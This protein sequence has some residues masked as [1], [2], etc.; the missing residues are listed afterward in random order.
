[1]VPVRPDRPFTRFPRVSTLR[2]RPRR[3]VDARS[4]AAGGARGRVGRGSDGLRQGGGG[5]G[6]DYSD[7]LASG[8]GEQAGERL[9]ERLVLGVC[10][11]EG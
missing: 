7:T 2:H 4:G 5:L 3:R 9:A 6:G 10:D 1:M 11:M 8:V